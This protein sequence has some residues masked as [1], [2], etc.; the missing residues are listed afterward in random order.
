MFSKAKIIWFILV[1]I[2]VIGVLVLLIVLAEPL[3]KYI[4]VETPEK[5]ENSLA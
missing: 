1:F 4:V 3:K 5:I 2:I